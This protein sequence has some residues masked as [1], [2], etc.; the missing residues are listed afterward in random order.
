MSIVFHKEP[1]QTLQNRAKI[2]HRSSFRTLLTLL[3]QKNKSNTADNLPCCLAASL[4]CPCASVAACMD[5]ARQT[6]DTEMVRGEPGK[7]RQWGRREEGRARRAHGRMMTGCEDEA[8][9]VC[10]EIKGSRQWLCNQI[11]ATNYGFRL[12]RL[13]SKAANMH[14]AGLTLSSQE[15]T[16]ML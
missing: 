4:P 8:R 7:Q 3:L 12:Y 9:T 14:A 11:Y 15:L 10:A 2:S 6:E 16:Y 1:D 13:H 5:R